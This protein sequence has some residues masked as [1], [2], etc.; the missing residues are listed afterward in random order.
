MT[1]TAAREPD[2]S[3]VDPRSRARAK[4]GLAR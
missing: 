4:G 1:C 3:V 2:L